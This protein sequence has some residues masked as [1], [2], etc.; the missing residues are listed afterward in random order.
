MASKSIKLRAKLADGETTV[1][2]LLTHPMES[3]RRKDK[4]T[5]ELIPAEFIQEVTCEHEGKTVFSAMCG[6]GL[7]KNPYLSFIFE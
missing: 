7:S 2:A 5:G 6:P 4:A 3:G 1:K